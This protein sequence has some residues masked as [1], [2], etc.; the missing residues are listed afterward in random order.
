MSTKLLRNR[1][2]TNIPI[3]RRRQTTKPSN[4]LKNSKTPVHLYSDVVASRPPSQRAREEIALDRQEPDPKSRPNEIAKSIIDLDNSSSDQNDT[5]WITVQ[6]RCVR[7]LDS[8]KSSKYD[9]N[10]VHFKTKNLTM[11]QQKTVKAAAEALTKEEMVRVQHRQEIVYEHETDNE[12]Q[13]ESSKS[14]G[15]TIDPREWGNAGINHEELMPETQAAIFDV[16]KDDNRI[17]RIP[18]KEKSRKSKNRKSSRKFSD[19]KSEDD[20]NFQMPEVSRHKSIGPASHAQMTEA[21]HADCRPVAQIAPKGSLGVALGKV[22]LRHGGRPSSH[23][24]KRRGST[25]LQNHLQI[26]KRA[27]GLII[28]DLLIL[29]IVGDLINIVDVATDIL[30]KAQK[31]A[32]HQSSQ[33]LLKTMMARQIPEPITVL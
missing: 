18:K 5:P 26:L 27:V 2:I 6:R 22:A 28:P 3:T 15:K 25:S 13:P 9:K 19:S 33:Y 12:E 16:Y 7:S 31:E 23:R 10:V 30:S 8:A 11:E 29:I 21:R 20:E 14:K 1:T 24:T 32:K 4:E 17:K